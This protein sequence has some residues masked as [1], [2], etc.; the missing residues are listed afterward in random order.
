MRALSMVLFC[1]GLLLG[2]AF[3]AATVWAD[4]EASLFEPSKAAQ[5]P[6]SSLRCPLIITPQESGTITAT[7]TNPGERALRRVVR[8]TIS[9]G[10]SSLMREVEAQF[11]LEPGETHRLEWTVT[12]ADAAWRHFILVRV[13]V[14][15]NYPLPSRTGSCGVLVM[16]LP[17]MTG[18]QAVALW[19]TASLVSMVAGLGLWSRATKSSPGPLPD[20][21]RPLILLGA[22]VVA[23]MLASLIGWW[24]ISGLLL[25]FALVV[26]ISVITWA[27]TKAG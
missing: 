13:N 27:V 4:L 15:R 16:N 24:M 21:T 17:G 5:E 18:N 19:F 10:F 14:L 3:V 12:A 2:M 26:T 11:M 1:V 8:G 6:L 22:I 7:F 9:H 23:S 20:L 25:I